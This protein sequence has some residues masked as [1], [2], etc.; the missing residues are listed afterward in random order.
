ME[1]LVYKIVDASQ[2][3]QAVK[4]NRFGGSPVD[5]ADGFI[6]L[7]SARQVPE[8]LRIH[9]RDRDDLVLVAI[10]A[11]A[12]GDR[13]K[14]EVSRGGERYPHLYGELA[15]DQVRSVTAISRDDS[16]RHGVAFD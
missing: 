10:D 14:W 13:L 6:H 9:F 11:M 4:Q 15:C 16:G 8:T 2:W 5:L 3:E 1:T 12:L 7:S